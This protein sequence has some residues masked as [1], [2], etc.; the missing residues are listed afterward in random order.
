MQFYFLDFQNFFFKTRL[1]KSILKLIKLVQDKM[2][3]NE[4]FS[5]RQI[6]YNL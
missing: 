1:V 6:V 4:K 2:V 3:K 5:N